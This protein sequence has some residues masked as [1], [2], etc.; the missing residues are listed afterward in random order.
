MTEF[1]NRRHL[2]PLRRILRN[3]APPA[4][5]RLWSRLKGKQVNGCK[6]RRQFSVENYVID[7]YCPALKLAIE[8]DGRSHYEAGAA[9][10]DSERQRLIERFGIRILRFTNTYICTNMDGVMARIAEETGAPNP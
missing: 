9:A 4:E 7:F 8:I 2:T 3:G 1:F 5:T 10:Y 6:F